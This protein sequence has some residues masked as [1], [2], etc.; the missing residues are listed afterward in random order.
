MQQLAK[1]HAAKPERRTIVFLSAPPGTGKSTLTT[2]WEYLSRQ[3]A[4]LPEIQTL[5]MDGFHYYNRWLEAHH[6]RACKGVPE[7][8]DVDKLAEN[9]RQVRLARRPGRSTTDSGTTRWNTLLS[10]RRRS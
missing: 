2:F 6:L 10:S 8:F 5:P 3:D 4:D 7:T 9:L 1:I